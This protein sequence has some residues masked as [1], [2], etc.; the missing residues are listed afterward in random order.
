MK[1]LIW[2]SLFLLVLTGLYFVS[3]RKEI[4]YK[5][6]LNLWGDPPPPPPEKYYLKWTVDC[7]ECDIVWGRWEVKGN[8][9][10]WE[11]AG[12]ETWTNPHMKVTSLDTSENG[13]IRAYIYAND[14]LCSKCEEEGANVICE[15][16]CDLNQ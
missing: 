12:Y 9:G 5:L 10:Y 15:M 3:C 7:S 6:D 13:Y 8:K 16:R 2:F 11:Y 14:H 1:R 4:D